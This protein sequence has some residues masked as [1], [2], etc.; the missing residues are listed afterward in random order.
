MTLNDVLMGERIPRDKE[1]NFPKTTSI[2]RSLAQCLCSSRKKVKG[3]YISNNQACYN[4][5]GYNLPYSF[6]YIVK[7]GFLL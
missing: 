7:Q 5:I 4:W 6:E 3:V 2:N 1:R